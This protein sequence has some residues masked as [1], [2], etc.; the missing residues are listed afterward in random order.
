MTVKII[1]PCRNS[2]EWIHIICAWWVPEVKI[3]DTDHIEKI[4]LDKIPVSF[5]DF[6]IIK[7]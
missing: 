1:F 4:T 2:F 7:S 5:L 3:E 6:E